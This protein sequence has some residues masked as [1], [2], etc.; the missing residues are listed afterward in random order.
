MTRLEEAIVIL[1]VAAQL[2]D[3]DGIE[4][5]VRRGVDDR[6]LLLDGDRLI[7]RLLQDLDQAA[8]AIELRLRR[9]VEVAAELRERGQLTVLGKVEAQRAGDLAHRLDL[10]RS[11]EI[12]RASCRERGA[13]P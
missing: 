10:R 13:V 2:V 4:E 8:A 12:G 3:L 1:F 7:L 9:L 11:A 6:H 5:A